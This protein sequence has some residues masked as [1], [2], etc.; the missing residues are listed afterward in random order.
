MKKAALFAIL[1]AVAA[2]AAAL[3]VKVIRDR[4]EEEID[5]TECPCGCEPDE[6]EETSEEAPAEEAP[7]QEEASEEPEVEVEITVESSD[8]TDPREE[9]KIEEEV[10]EEAPAEEAPA[11]EEAPA[12]EKPAEEN[13]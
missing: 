9:V 4:Q 1:G 2:G 8:E 10:S 5:Y 13:K 3:C 6:E 7:A 11:Q 12:E